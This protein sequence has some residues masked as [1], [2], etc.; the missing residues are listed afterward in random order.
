MRLPT[1]A[2]L[3]LRRCWPG[4]GN[5]GGLRIDRAATITR[6]L[7]FSPDAPNGIAPYADL[8][9]MVRTCHF[10]GL[11]F[12]EVALLLFFADMRFDGIAGAAI[13]KHRQTQ[14]QKHSHYGEVLVQFFVKFEGLGRAAHSQ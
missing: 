9:R 4:S 8:D 14:R 13:G 5:G 12:P 7:G 11:R 2:N 10:G 1:V 3:R 6:A